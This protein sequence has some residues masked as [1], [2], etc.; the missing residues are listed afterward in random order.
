M[1]GVGV[2][3]GTTQ[4]GT[5]WP[6]PSGWGSP[7]G[8]QGYPTTVTGT[9]A[10]GVA[11]PSQSP[12]TG[13]TSGWAN[14]YD[15]EPTNNPQP[16]YQNPMAFGYNPNT[17]PPGYGPLTAIGSILGSPTT[18]PYLTGVWDPQT[19]G[20]A[21]YNLAPVGQLQSYL[22]PFQQPQMLPR[23]GMMGAGGSGSFMGG[24]ATGVVSAAGNQ[25]QQ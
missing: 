1:S 3:V 23:Y 5:P 18:S 25:Q 21:N 24:T 19:Q 20:G 4:T 7:S 15:G 13:N 22:Q 10:A 17:G 11:G 8:W 6:W 14:K 16:G 2:A 9:P 12:G